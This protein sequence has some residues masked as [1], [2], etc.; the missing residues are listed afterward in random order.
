[1]NQTLYH[2]YTR[3]SCHYWNENEIITLKAHANA[4]T[5]AQRSDWPKPSEIKTVS[6][7]PTRL[8]FAWR[9]SGNSFDC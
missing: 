5:L 6:I 7:H 2:Y 9:V 8:G 1:M 4:M 3:G